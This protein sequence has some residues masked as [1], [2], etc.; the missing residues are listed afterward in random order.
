MNRRFFLVLLAI[1]LPLQSVMAFAAPLCRHGAEQAQA[2]AAEAIAQAEAAL[3]PCHQMVAGMDH[4]AHGPATGHQADHDGGSCDQCQSC[5]LAFSG[6][7]P[8]RQPPLHPPAPGADALPTPV[9]HY[10]SVVLDQPQ[11]PPLSAVL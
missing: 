1:W 10:R 2:A 8:P 9:N 7:L 6:A 11:R 5:H 3:A 4:D